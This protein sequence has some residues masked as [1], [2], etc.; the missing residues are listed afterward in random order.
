MRL[1]RKLLL[2]GGRLGCDAMRAAVETGVAVIDDRSVVNHRLIDIG[3][4][5]YGGVYVDGSGVIRKASTAPFAAGEANAAKSEP[6]VHTSIKAYMGAPIAPMK[7]IYAI[8]PAPISGCP[9]ITRARSE[10]PGT[11]NPIII[12]I[13]GVP[14]PISGCPHKV[15]RRAGWLHIYGEYRGCDV[16]GNADGYLSERSCRCCKQCPNDNDIAKKTTS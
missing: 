1:T 10:H 16:D 14:S 3:V 13:I 11:R 4:M 6:I 2:F 7:E 5:N 12:A 15:R 8:S 9:Q